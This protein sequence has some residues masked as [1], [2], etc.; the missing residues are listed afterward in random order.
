MTNVTVTTNGAGGAVHNTTIA[1]DYCTIQSAID[2]PL[3]LDGHVITVDAGTYNEDV[4]VNKSLTITG[5]GA[6]TTTV[7]GPIGG[8][9]STFALAANNIDLSGFTITRDGN[10]TTDW[11]NAGLNSA[12]ISIQGQSI[13]GAVIHDNIITGM[14]TA[15]D[16]NN[17]NGHT[18]RNNRI[19][20]NRTGLIFRNQT[21][22]ITFTENEVT[23]NW[24]VGILF[25]DASGGT[26]VPVQTALNCNFYNN[27]ISGNWYGQIVDRQTGGSLPAAGTTNLKNFSGNWYGSNTPVVTT[28]NSAEPGYAVLIPVVYG[29]TAAPPGGQPDIAGPASA[30]FDYTPYLNTGTDVNIETTLG[31]GTFGFQGSFSNLW[32]TKASAQTGAT[33]RIQ[34]GVNMVSGSTVNVVAGT[35]TESVEINVNDLVM[36]GANANVDPCTGGRGAET[37]ITGTDPNGLINVQANNVVIN[38][39]KLVPVGTGASGTYGILVNNTKTGLEVKN[40]IIDGASSDRDGINTWKGTSAHLHHNQIINALYGI[41]G[42][43]DNEFSPTSAIIEDN[44]IDNTRLGVT[45]YHNGSTIRRN[46]INNF[47]PAGPSAGISGQLLNTTVTQNTITNFPNGAGIALTAYGTRPNSANTTI[48]NN[49][50]NN[51]GAALYADAPATLVGVEAHYNDLSNNFYSV[52]NLSTASFNATCNWHGSADHATVTS[53]ISGVVSYVPYLTHGDEDLIT[54]GFQTSETC[55]CTIAVTTT[56]TDA[57]CP[58]LNDGTATANVTGAAGTFTYSWNTSPVQTTQTA[59]GL[60][61]GTYTVTVTDENG[62]VATANATVSNTAVMPV[63][64]VNTGL[65]YC[66]IQ[67]AINDVLTLN[68]HVITVAAGTY[69]ENVVLNKSLTLKGAQFGVDARGR[70]TGSPNPAVESVISPASG[71]AIDIQSSN[72]IID[73][74]AMLGNTIGTN[75]VIQTLAG[76]YTT[77]QIRN[78]YLKVTS[79]IGQALWLN[80][81]ITDVTIDKNEMIGGSSS[82]QVIFMNGPQSF[83]G[84]YFTNNKVTGS[85]SSAGIFVDGNRNVGTS[86]TPRNPLLQGNLFDGLSVGIN[87][88]SRS[89]ENTQFLENTF[90]NVAFDGFQGGPKNSNFARNTFSNNGRYGL[91]LTAFGSMADGTRGAQ[92]TTVQNNFFFNNTTADIRTSDQI[93]GTQGTNTIMNNS[94]L[95]TIAIDNGEPNGG[96]DPVQATCNWF[97]TTAYMAIAAKIN[98]VSG[99]ITIYSPWLTNGTDD[100]LVTPGFQPVAGSCNGM[101]P[102]MF[103]V[104]DNVYD[105]NDIYTTAVGNDANDGSVGA[106]FRTITKAISVAAAGNT[107]FVDAGTFQE[108]VLISK[109]LTVTGNDLT[110]TIIKA[111][112][113]VNNVSNANASDHRPIVYA[114]G[115]G[116]T[117]DISKVTVD[118]DGRGGARFYGVY[119][120]AAGGSF[121]DSKITRVRDASFSGVQSGHAFFANH[122]Y[123]VILAQTVTVNNNIIEDYQKTGVLINELNTQGIVTNNIITGQ[124]IPNVNGQNGVQFGYGAYGTI[125]GNTISNNIYNGPSAD[126]ATGILLAG[127]GVNFSNTATGNATT[128]GGNIL[129]GNEAGL[130]ADAGGFGYDSNAGIVENASTY[131][132][133]PIHVLFSNSNVTV[134]NVSNTYDKR[135][136]NTSQT[137]AVYGQIQKAIDYASSGNTLNASAGTFVENITV[138]KPLSILGPNA[139]INPNTGS[140][141]SEAIIMPAIDDAEGGVLVNIQASNVIFKGFLLDGDNPSLN[142]GNA[143]GS[144]DVN[145]S[146]GIANAADPV[147]GPFAQ[148]DHLTIEN[149][150][151]NNF[152][153]Q[154]IYLEVAFNSNHS[155]NYIKNNKFDNMWEGVQTYAMHA[156]ISDNV[157]TAVDRAVSMHGVNVDC[158]AGFV[159][160]IA[161]NEATINWKNPNVTTRNVGIWVNY[162]RGTAPVLAVSG[163][164]LHYPT[165]A[166]SGKTFIGFYALTITDDRTITFSD[167]TIDGQNNVHRGFYMSN[168][169]SANV[170]LTGGSFNNIKEHGVLMSTND[171]TWGSGDVRLTIN[172]VPIAMSAGS[173]AAVAVDAPAANSPYVGVLD[174]SNSTIS[175][176]SGTGVLVKGSLASANIHN[177]AS[178]IT[179]FVIGVDIDGGSASLFQNDINTNGTG[180]RVKNSG[181]LTSTTENFIKNNTGDGISVESTAGTIGAI[182]NNDL[183]GNGGYAINNASGLI[184]DASCNWYGSATPAGVAA[185]INGPVNYVSW[186]TDGTDNDGGTD[187]FQAVP[188]SCNGVLTDYYV[189][190]NSLTGDVYTTAIGNDAN[191]GTP[192]APFATMQHAMSVAPAGSNIYVDAGTYNLTSAVVVNKQVNLYGAQA[193]VDAETRSVANESFLDASALS[194]YPSTVFD[195]QPAGSESIIDGFTLKGAQGGQGVGSIYMEA[196]SN[197]TIVRNNIIEGADAVVGIFIANNSATKQTLIEQNLFRNNTATGPSSGH[198]IYA[199]DFTASTNLQNVLVKDNKFTNTITIVD[200]WAVGLFGNGSAYTMDENITFQDNEVNNHAGRGMY[201]FGTS[202]ATIT[203]NT[204]TGCNKLCYR[205]F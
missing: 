2:D 147:L 11:D 132:N 86:A 143:V 125:T 61:A 175:G 47:T 98:N 196:G 200:T 22:N 63:Q 123:D 119:Y 172:N 32:V 146:E 82:S 164:T 154:A 52:Q 93:N 70:V 124:N 186:L 41:G 50:V 68:G 203:G 191:S 144:A 81:G 162:R 145:T 138:S 161:N 84:M 60:I 20:F 25:L 149:N 67:G 44:C 74:F 33:E 31:R 7:S 83:A 19:T 58:S 26:N 101:P 6:G 96:T 104:N 183:S 37:I 192:A 130:Y 140:R 116:N 85:T 142:A 201:F 21:D 94:L 139:A 118:G 56:T 71:A 90:T 62:C 184:S 12:G 114:S 158:D 39:V 168:S 109:S 72:S 117:V 53:K 24:T 111:P 174:I 40:T 48:T 15:I 46:I 51:N 10:N 95:S 178:T 122:T 165:A 34:E 166:P 193:G 148:V 170:S 121:T 49:F 102:T 126:V 73:G 91:A 55:A 120:F 167:N 89:F 80:R 173:T 150:K 107:I 3:T 36:N 113:T 30:N 197:G 188:N 75:G 112:A 153:Y 160:Q 5:A 17:S 180:V 134:P 105:G 187:G 115:A 199:D 194:G 151:F 108:Q 13:T 129:S 1:K 99:A 92:G 28:A 179:G 27:N 65:Y 152:D 128:I 171:A 45:G 189:N 78:N 66:T 42:G 97:G 157:F 14:R 110:K 182:N 205:Y 136:D 4:N 18:I 59:T 156:D 79:T 202:N 57:N 204:F 23:D 103:Y 54:I 35:Y 155:W 127:A 131:S 69:P 190:D 8:S 177:N 195:I 169:P 185:E 43:S 106:P 100:D 16:I 9:G 163:N 135:V 29:G 181:N 88:G 137:Y 64:N 141:V 87:G 38:G 198:S 133:Q 159:P 176:S 77:D 76:P